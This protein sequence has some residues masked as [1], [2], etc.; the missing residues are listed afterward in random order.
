MIGLL[1]IYH[2]SCSDGVAIFKEMIAKIESL[3]VL[4]ETTGKFLE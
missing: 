3:P 1:A 4:D 2:E